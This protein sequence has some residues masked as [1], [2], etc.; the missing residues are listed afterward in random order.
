MW[1]SEYGSSSD[2]DALLRH[3]DTYL[4][5]TW[6]R[7]GLY[8]ERKSDLAWDEEGNYRYVDPNTGNGC[9][10]YARLNVKNG[11]KKM[12]DEP[13]TRQTVERRP[14]IDNVTLDQGCDCLRGR[15][16]EDNQAMIATFRTWNDALGQPI[17]LKPIIKGLPTGRY[18]V[19]VDGRLGDVQ[20]VR[21]RGDEVD[22]K[23]DVGVVDV[24][25]VVVRWD[26][27]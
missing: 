4:N 11:L 6:S 8:Y 16:D 17:S 13:W 20:T 12:W 26:E 2:L 7:G 23:L 10:A 14:Y 24:D 15:W 27:I 22:V 18:S 5:P 3:A 19:F 25:L 9:I 21:E 1:V